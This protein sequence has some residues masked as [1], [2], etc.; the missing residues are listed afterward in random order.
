MENDKYNWFIYN[1]EPIQNNQNQVKEEK[2]TLPQELKKARLLENN[3]NVYNQPSE[4]LFCLQGK[5]LEDYEDNF[6]YT[7][8]VVHYF[9]T[10][11]AL[12]NDELRGYFTWR[13]KIR[14]GII[15]KTSLS[16]AFLYIYELLNQIGT[17]NPLDGF[18]KLKYFKEEYEKLDEGITKYLIKWLRDYV[19]YYHLDVS[20]LDNSIEL[21]YDNNLLILINIDKHSDQEIL[22]A[23]NF[24]SSYKISIHLFIKYIKMIWNNNCKIFYK[25]ILLL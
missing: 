14:N 21:T 7:L 10:Y 5:L 22:N 23:I 24:L 8:P 20:L 19:V 4:S 15:E 11:K 17:D 25:N 2:N 3:I 12:T 13:T 1:D 18:R 16:Y 9:P 6:E